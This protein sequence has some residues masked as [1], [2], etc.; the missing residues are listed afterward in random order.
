[1]AEIQFIVDKL[2]EPPFSKDLR[3]VTFD[4]KSPADLLQ[5]LDEIFT[6][7]DPQ[8]TSEQ[9]EP[10]D[11]STTRMM[12][13]L[14]M[15]KFPV[16]EPQREEF[17]RGLAV[18]DK[19]V[20]YQAMH[21]CLQ[22][23]PQLKKRAYLARYLMPVEVPMEFMQDQA[24]VDLHESYRQLQA[25]FKATH[26]QVDQAR[27]TDLRP[28]ELRT[29]I[30]QLEDEKKQLQ[31]KISKLQENVS[32]EPGFAEMLD[33]T[34]R[35]RK[36]QEETSELSAKSAQQ[37]AQL[38]QSEARVEAARRR[39]GVLRQG[40][41]SA[42]TA[43]AVLAQ[44]QRE[45]AALDSKLSQVLPTE[46]AQK[47]RKL[48]QLEREAAEPQRTREDVQEM[49]QLEYQL[50]REN[51]VT[52]QQIDK[53]IAD[54]PDSNLNMLRQPAALAAK[55]RSEKEGEW[56]RLQ[57]ERAKLAAEIEQKESKVGGLP[58]G[59][60]G[61]GGSNGMSK[62]ELRQYG[63]HLRE[64]TQTYLKMKAELAAIRAESVV[65]RRTEQ[66]LKS[67]DENLEEFLGEMEAE[68]GITGYRKVQ[69]DLVAKSEKTAQ[70]D[71]MKGDTLQAISSLVNAIT[72]ELKSRKESL[73]PLIEELKTTRKQCMEIEAEYQ[74]KRGGHDKVA[75]GLEVERQQLEHECNTSQEDALAQE[76]RYHFLQ[77]LCSIAEARLQSV[78]QD[79]RWEKG[80]GRLLPEFQCHRDLYEHKLR[81]QEA[82]SK[83]LRRQQRTIKDSEGSST[84][85]RR[86]FG[87]LHAL[88]K[89]KMVLNGGGGVDII[90]GGGIPIKGSGGGGSGGGSRGRGGMDEAY[91]KAIDA[92]QGGVGGSGGGGRLGGAPDVMTLEDRD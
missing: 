36:A 75:V 56:E 73:R 68:K 86:M 48:E 10:G 50:Q 78:R 9:H 71:A 90:G 14:V 28:G 40:T 53:A 24:L 34:S 39:L 25:D 80:E 29:E 91:L 1:M 31:E 35:L 13:F 64:K 47:S 38:H 88:L 22:R 84:V 12:S 62:E 44:L 55:K 18:G 66:I 70:V 43:A 42:T 82:L 85:Q 69:A 72:V 45:V 23:L 4:E 33:V 89:C 59:G 57:E 52:K 46:I 77:S 83:Q 60:K 27:N 20:V 49:E 61:A 87:G 67:R 32:E 30:G 8:Q 26:K 63:A 5:Q 76:S 16:P 51:E 79:E 81:Q 74:E 58:S 17:R 15:L 41:A 3:L 37:R 7:I 11:A 19:D 92:Q 2:N 6:A 54:R 65:L 21:W